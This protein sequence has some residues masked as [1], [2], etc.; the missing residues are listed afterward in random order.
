MKNIVYIINIFINNKKTTYAKYK[1]LETALY[2][3]DILKS[4]GAKVEL[5]KWINGETIRLDVWF[6]IYEIKAI[7]LLTRIAN[8]KHVPSLIKY[9]NYGGYYDLFCY[10]KDTKDY[11][12][13]K[14]DLLIFKNAN[15]N[16]V[17]TYYEDFEEVQHEN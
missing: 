12:N 8:D 14:G 5:I 1:E 4:N 2:E 6:M 13:G 10:D 9:N 7:E 11:V 3:Y 15:L 16:D 17:I